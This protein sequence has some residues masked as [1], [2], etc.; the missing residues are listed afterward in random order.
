MSRESGTLRRYQGET[1]WPAVA[2]LHVWG[3]ENYTDTL[4]GPGVF[5]YRL[6][7]LNNGGP[8]VPGEI[9]TASAVQEEAARQKSRR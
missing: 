8:G 1:D 2:T 5:E 3:P 9:G 6:T 7:G 4:P